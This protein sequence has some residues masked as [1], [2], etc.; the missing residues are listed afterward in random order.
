MVSLLL[1][2][3]RTLFEGHHNVCKQP[4]I[5]SHI[6]VAGARSTPDD[7]KG[8]GHAIVM[9]KLHLAFALYDWS[10]P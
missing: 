5:L 1:C 8:R 6:C 7:F 10:F 9:R 4:S 2:D 3:S